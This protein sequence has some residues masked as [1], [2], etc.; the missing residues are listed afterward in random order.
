MNINSPL[1]RKFITLGRIDAETVKLKQRE[2][3][4]TAE[5][6]SKSCQIDG[7]ELAE[8]CTDLFRVPYFDI[9]DFDVSLISEELIKEK[10]IRE[11][12]ILPL[13]KKG[14]KL[15]IAA[16]DPTDYGAFE[17]FE[18]STGLSCEVV[19]VDYNQLENKIEQ[20]L[21]ATGGL[22]LS[23]DEF[24]ELGD[25]ETEKPKDISGSDE[26]KDDATSIKY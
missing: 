21:D 22:H 14:R 24:K 26:D 5:L 10:L 6:I 25:L 16:S 7:H 19:V 17:N 1:L 11:H 3:N 15:Y 12:H 13:I 20:L 4:S 18:F 8:Q 2:Y 9:K 23:E